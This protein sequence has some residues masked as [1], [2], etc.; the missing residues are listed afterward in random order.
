MTAGDAPRLQE[1]RPSPFSGSTRR[2]HGTT[3]TNQP[4][5]VSLNANTLDEITPFW[6][7]LSARRHHR[8]TACGARLEPRLRRAHRPLRRHVERHRPASHN[9]LSRHRHLP[10]PMPSPPAESTQEVVYK[11]RY[12]DDVRV[13]TLRAYVEAFGARLVLVVVFD[14]EVPQGADPPRR[15]AAA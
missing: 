14:D 3:I 9:E 13:S 6:E 8:R 2:Q 12:S 5:F 11:M 15:D 1:R 7:R 10:R 4:F